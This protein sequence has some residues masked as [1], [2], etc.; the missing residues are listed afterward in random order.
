MNSQRERC[1]EGDNAAQPADVA[2]SGSS[3]VVGNGVQVSNVGVPIHVHVYTTTAAAPPMTT[4]STNE[5]ALTP[6]ER[7]LL[8]AYRASTFEAQAIIQRAA[9]RAIKLVRAASGRQARAN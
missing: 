8:D 6:S 3:N 7:Q 5:L 4:A 2:I 1:V 9:Q